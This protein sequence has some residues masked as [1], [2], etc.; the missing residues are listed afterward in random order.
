M[1]FSSAAAE[2]WP[3]FLLEQKEAK[4][5]DPLEASARK[6]PTHGS[7][8]ESGQRYQRRDKHLVLNY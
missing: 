5:Q 1:L 8:S 3:S 7:P 2:A 6:N 4:I